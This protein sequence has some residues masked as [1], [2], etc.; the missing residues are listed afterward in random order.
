MKLQYHWS[1][2]I[3]KHIWHVIGFFLFAYFLFHLV[4]GNRGLLVWYE[5]Q[6]E[7]RQ[8]K[9]NL[10]KAIYDREKKELKVKQ[11]RSSSLNL[12]TL[13]E[14]IRKTLNY[15]DKNDLILKDVEYDESFF[16]GDTE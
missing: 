8:A 3:Y 4:S 5:I 13:E 10:S 7:I 2:Y 9:I 6:D 14:Q 11:M 15:V 12:D 16:E 1:H